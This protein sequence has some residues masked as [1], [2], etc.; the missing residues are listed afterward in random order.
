LFGYGYNANIRAEIG[1]RVRDYRFSFTDPRLFDSPWSVGFDVFKETYTYTYF[2]TDVE[3]GDIR[4][5][6]EITDIIRADIT[7]VYERVDIYNVQS[8][9]YEPGDYIYDNQGVNTV[10]KITLTVSRHTIDNP[11]NPTKGSDMFISESFA[12][13]GGDNYFYSTSGGISWFHPLVGDLVLNL[14]ADAGFMR[15]Y[16]GTINM[17]QKFYVGGNNL[18]GFEYGMAGP[19]DE[20]EEPIG[21]LYMT[22][23][24]VEFL[25]PLSKAIG[26]RGAVFYDIGKGWGGGIPGV[27]PVTESFLPLRHAVGVGIRWFSPFGPIRIDWGWNINEK[28]NRGEKSNA[29]NFNMGA[30][31]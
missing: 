31:F 26:L 18:R 27:D 1:Q 4:F 21:A 13:L 17:T 9:P 19:V 24:T 29:W 10:G 14:R 7:Y 22:V 5:G 25:Y 28:P 30:M 20:Y 12:G 8:P 2:S 11:Y 3:G 15:P 6:R 16:K 23:G